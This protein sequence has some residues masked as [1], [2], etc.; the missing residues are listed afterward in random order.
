MTTRLISK[1]EFTLVLTLSA[2]GAAVIL[3]GKAMFIPNLKPWSPLLSDYSESCNLTAINIP[4]PLTV[5]PIGVAILVATVILA[6]VF[7]LRRDI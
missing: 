6:A 4:Q 1:L 7:I 3:L 5:A 2:L